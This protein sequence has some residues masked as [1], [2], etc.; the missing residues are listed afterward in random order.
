[1]I[2]RSTNIIAFLFVLALVFSACDRLLV[3]EQNQ[4][5][6]AKGWAQEE[7]LS[8]RAEINDTLGLHQIY[9]NVR[10]TTDYAY[11]NLYL[12][13]DIEFPGGTLLRDTIEGILADRSGQ[14]TGS[15]FG[16]IKSNRFLFRDQVW[17]PETG[18]YTFTLQQAMREEVLEG[19]AD[20]G[21]RIERK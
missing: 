11:R 5:I 10:N 13:L 19:I 15:G 14:W 9:L 7:K 21:I 12:F 6:S 17:F 2:L 1:M 16:S 8:F 18:T 3:F 20:I 4:S